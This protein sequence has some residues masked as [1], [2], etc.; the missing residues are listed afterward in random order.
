MSEQSDTPLIEGAGA[1]APDRRSRRWRIETAVLIL[2]AV[3][4]L[5]VSVNDTARQTLINKRLKVDLVTW[6]HYTGL[7]TKEP[8]IEQN[9]FGLTSNIEVVCGDTE[10]GDPE[11]SVRQ[12][13]VIGGPTRNGLRIVLGGYKL[14]PYLDDKAWVRYDCFGSP[15]VTRTCRR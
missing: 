5:V 8:A 15:L 6:S 7:N 1:D 3:V 12:C 11:S 10:Y 4:L 9:V 2:A 14:P 13:A